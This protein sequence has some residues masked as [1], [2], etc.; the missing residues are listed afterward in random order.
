MQRALPTINDFPRNPK[1][2]EFSVANVPG[3]YLLSPYDC[4]LALT[5]TS[6]YLLPTPLLLYPTYASDVLVVKYFFSAPSEVM[7]NGRK[8]Y[9]TWRGG[10]ISYLLGVSVMFLKDTQLSSI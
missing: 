5:V 6:E 10:G 7:N 4:C 8:T 9:Q 3:G 2:L 1:R